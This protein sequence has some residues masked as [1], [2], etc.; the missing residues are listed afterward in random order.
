MNSTSRLFLGFFALG[1]KLSTAATPLDPFV[2]VSA[3]MRAQAS[4]VAQAARNL[5]QAYQLARKEDFNLEKLQRDLALGTKMLIEANSE[6]EGGDEENSRGGASTP[7]ERKQ[8]ERGADARQG[9]LTVKNYQIEESAEP[10]FSL[11]FLLEDHDSEAQEESTDPVLVGDVPH[12]KTKA[13]R[14]LLGLIN[15]FAKENFAAHN[16]AYAAAIEAYDDE[17][18]ALEALLSTAIAARFA[19]FLTVDSDDVNEDPRQVAHAKKEKVQEL[20]AYYEGPLAEQIQN[21]ASAEADILTQWTAVHK[22]G[23]LLF[24]SKFVGEVGTDLQEEISIADDN[25]YT[26]LMGRLKALSLPYAKTFYTRY[27]TVTLPYDLANRPVRPR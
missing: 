8:P 2:T 27:S 11:L 21:Q 9:F 7:R 24:K 5:S 23:T 1:L 20:L 16:P 15:D 14:N 22:L 26:L 3:E 19:E 10:R 6:N 12:K 4:K 25:V 13:P 17:S 18:K